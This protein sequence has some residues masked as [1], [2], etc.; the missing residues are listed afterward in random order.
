MKRYL[1]L[2]ASAMLF[3]FLYTGCG[4]SGGSAAQDVPVEQM[5]EEYYAE[6]DSLNSAEPQKTQLP[7]NRKWVITAEV[8]TETED[9]DQTVDAVMQRVSELKGYV[10]DQ[11][12][13]NGSAYG[14]YEPERSA[15]MTVRIPA[16]NIDDFMETVEEKTNVVSSSRNLQD[17]TLQYTDTET[18]IAALEAE[19]KRLLEFMEQAETMADLLEIERRLTDVHYELENVN[20]RLRTYDNKVNYATIRLNIQEVREYTPVEEPSFPERVTTGFVASLH[21]VWEGLVD[22]T[23]LLI[24]ASPYLVVWGI[25][26]LVI[27]LIVRAC[28]KR[29][30]KK[31]KKQPAAA[32]VQSVPEE[33]KKFDSIKKDQPEKEE[34]PKEEK[35]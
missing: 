25:I 15:W 18:R 24:V 27:V 13:D 4:S 23:V 28:R 8:H 2:I 35:K 33:W 9:M 7:D 16:E 12:F 17:I 14:G 1:S 11:N 20:S 29:G 21:G 5:A 32:K 10:E 3:L 34:P 22:F 6:N 19:E 26:I 31:P 30:G